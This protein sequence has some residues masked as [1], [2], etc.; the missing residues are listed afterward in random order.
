MSRISESSGDARLDDHEDKLDTLLEFCGNLEGD[1]K[2][3][4]RWTCEWEWRLDELWRD[5]RNG[6]Q[7]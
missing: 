3:L 2:Y 7:G 5:R 6:Y 1:I 4:R